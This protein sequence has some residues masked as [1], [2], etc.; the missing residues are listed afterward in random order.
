MTAALIKPRA[1]R[2]YIRGQ[3]LKE[4]Q[5]QT[6]AE[7]MAWVEL[8]RFTAE[9]L[10]RLAG[11]EAPAPRAD[12]PHRE[13]RAQFSHMTPANSGRAMAAK[14]VAD[15]KAEQLDMLELERGIGEAVDDNLLEFPE[16]DDMGFF[17]TAGMVW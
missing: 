7:L 6:T 17:K 13:L 8:Q 3:A 12:D 11:I 5:A 9:R 16:M 15:T 2:P 1:A 14:I 10:P 4:R